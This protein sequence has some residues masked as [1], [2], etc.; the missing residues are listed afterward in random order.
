MI[1]VKSRAMGT[2]IHPYGPRRHRDAEPTS[3]DLE[4]PA[5]FDLTCHSRNRISRD[6][7]NSRS[8]CRCDGRSD[9]VTRNI[10]IVKNAR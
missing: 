3:Y 7:S 4:R 2:T 8:V 6:V 10:P 1:H 9:N 5:S